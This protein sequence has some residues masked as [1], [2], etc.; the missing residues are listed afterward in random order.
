MRRK[1]NKEDPKLEGIANDFLEDAKNGGLSL[2][3]EKGLI[4][5]LIRK[6]L[7]T[8]LDAEMDAHL[9]YSNNHRSNKNTEN[10]R[11][12]SFKKN[13]KTGIGSVN[14]NI[15]RDRNSDFNP[16][17]VPKHQRSLSGFSE[18]VIALYANGMTTRDICDY[19][20]KIYGDKVSPTLVSN[21]TNQVMDDLNV[22]KTRTLNDAYAVVF[23]DAIILKVNHRLNSKIPVYIAYGIDFDGYRDVLGIYILDDSSGESTKDWHRVMQDL[24]QR[25]VKDIFI[26]CADGLKGLPLVVEQVFPQ[27]IF[28]TCVV[29]MIR[30]SLKYIP[31]KD[32]RNVAK[33]LKEIYTAINPEDAAVKLELFDKTWGKNYPRIKKIW[34][35]QWN[36]FIP[37]LEFPQEVRTI[38]YTTNAIE[39]LNSRFKKATRNRKI[40]PNIDSA[41][42]ILY[43]AIIDKD[44]GRSVKCRVDKWS[45]IFPI[46]R[47]YFGKRMDKY[48]D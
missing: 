21:V 10:S 2:T 31:Y 38:I 26:V 20:R 28:Q 1:I 33:D 24:I 18:Q 29:H 6:V 19:L 17:I 27:A 34:E 45:N 13:L 9:G 5:E 43:L 11:N 25:G 15:P 4:N 7:Q 14:L 30:N 8:A 37:F 46:L 47:N 16:K 36:E 23:I 48:V 40:F 41:L 39:S 12:G 35:N 32:K 3:G 22:W 44:R 42:K